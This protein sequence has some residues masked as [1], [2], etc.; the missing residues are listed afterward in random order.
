MKRRAI[1]SGRPH[2]PVPVPAATMNASRVL[3][4]DDDV[5][6]AYERA[7]RDA[8]YNIFDSWPI[9]REMNAH[10][11]ACGKDGLVSVC[12]FQAMVLRFM[13][14]REHYRR[15]VARAER[16]ARD[17]ERGAAPPAGAAGAAERG[18]PIAA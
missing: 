16:A 12:D 11:A 17:R 18:A 4:A 14:N 9:V 10:L 5:V 1:P 2:R 8:R 3:E 7:R 13:D 15:C 6:L